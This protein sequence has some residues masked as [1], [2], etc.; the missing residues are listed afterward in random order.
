[1]AASADQLNEASKSKKRPEQ[2]ITQAISKK[3]QSY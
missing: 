3:K 1:V 2:E